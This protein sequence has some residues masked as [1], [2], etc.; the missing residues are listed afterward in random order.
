M[1]KFM[2]SEDWSQRMPQFREYII[3]FD[4]Q[5]G[6]DF[7]KVFPEMAGLLDETKDNA[8]QSELGEKISAK[9]EKELEHG[10]TI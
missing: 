1:V 7:T 6:T 9:L 10:G 4:K 2:M 3:K 5:R 8:K